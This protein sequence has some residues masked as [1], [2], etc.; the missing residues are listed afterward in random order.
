MTNINSV[1]AVKRLPIGTKLRLVNS[2][3]GPCDRARTLKEVR[4]KDLVF[5]TEKATLSYL[6]LTG[7]RVVATETGF[8]LVAKGGNVEDGDA[9]EGT[10]LAEYSL[11]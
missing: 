9:P 5:I 2:L 1:A 8:R 3:M 11:E 6:F 10:L 7:C 4:S